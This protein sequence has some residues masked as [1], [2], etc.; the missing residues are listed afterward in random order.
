M[1]MQL[2][3]ILKAKRM[4]SPYCQQNHSSSALNCLVNLPHTALMKMPN[5]THVAFTFFPPISNILRPLLQITFQRQ[6]FFWSVNTKQKYAGWEVAFCQVMCLNNVRNTWF[7]HYL[8]VM[9][10]GQFFVA[11]VGSAIFGLGLENFPLKIS[12]FSIFSPSGQKIFHWDG[13]KS[14]RAPDGSASYLLRVKSMLGLGWV[15]AHLYFSYKKWKPW[16]KWKPT[17]RLPLGVRV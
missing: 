1:T 8:L 17:W 2:Y 6:I 16:S 10:L 9:G 3:L 11:W 5:Q 13:S 14:T 15:S 12:N 7:V 4:Q